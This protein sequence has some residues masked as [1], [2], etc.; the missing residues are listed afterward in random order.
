MTKFFNYFNTNLLLSLIFLNYL[1]YFSFDTKF[2]FIFF[3]L[4]ILLT[5]IFILIKNIKVNFYIVFIIIIISLISLGSP[6]S[7]WD[8]RSI[9]LFNAKR[10]FFNFSLEEFTSY[11]G[12][13]FSHVDYPILVQTLSASLAT[14]IGHWNEIFP[15]FSNIIMAL[16]AM[17]IFT[18]IIK[19]NLT[20]LFLFILIFFIYEKR[21]INGDM[22]ALLSLYTCASL[23]LLI[24]YS[25]FKKLNFKHFIKLF[26]YLASLT[27][28][29]IEGIGI[30]MCLL[31]SYILINYKNN[32]K[33]NYKIILTF[34]VSIIPIF[35]WKLYILDKNII[36][37]SSL[38]ISGGER[39][40][41]N[42]F[43]FKF[44]LA[45][46]NGIFLNKQMFIAI[47]IFLISISRYIFLN[48]KNLQI[49]INKILIKNNSLFVMIAL[50]SYFLLLLLIFISSE[51]SLSNVQEIQFSMAKTA[52][53][54]LFL[55]IHSMLILCAIYLNQENRINYEDKSKK[56]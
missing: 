13:E 52:S 18:I 37:S 29:K 5:F 55:P 49:T 45:L 11:D 51:G 56:S 35:L 48:K 9:W 47:S 12:S 2:F 46:F 44:L 27:M 34:L 15:K 40:F 23:I 19:N 36:S 10:I 30:L 6:V 54:R 32:F 8:S 22:D 53:D 28:I 21:L 33:L 31:L 39:F 17:L 41:E 20:K 24:Q 3:S 7:D 43:N 42:L 1:I 26:L 4:S 16:P 38:M 50:S 14:L 25:N